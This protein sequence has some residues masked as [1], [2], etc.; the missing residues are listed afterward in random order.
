MRPNLFT[1]INKSMSKKKLKFLI[2]LNLTWS[3]LGI[4]AD[5]AWLSMVPP[6]LVPLTAICSLYPPLL[7]I[8]YCLKYFHRDIPN[9]YTFWLVIGT[10]SYGLLAQFYFPLLMSWQGIS[11]HDVG[12][13]FWVAV[14]GLQALIIF[15][16]LKIPSILTV[17]PGLTYLFLADYHHYF[18]PTFVDFTLPGYPEWMKYTTGLTALATQIICAIIIILLTKKRQQTFSTQKS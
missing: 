4:Y 11:F 10:A 8:W 13:M 7:L 6:H 12:S 17:L 1:R 15:P 9:W 2:I 3:L 18:I 5:L 14:Y 16:H